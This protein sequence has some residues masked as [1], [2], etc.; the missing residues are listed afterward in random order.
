M[1][2]KKIKRNKPKKA[3]V[4]VKKELVQLCVYVDQACAD[5]ARFFGRKNYGSASA[6]V[7]RLIQVEIGR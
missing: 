3:K 4:T 6:Y 1:A 2:K 5:Q 7:N